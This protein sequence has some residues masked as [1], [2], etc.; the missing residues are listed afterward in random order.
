MLCL[1]FTVKRKERLD[2]DKL[3][4]GLALADIEHSG[5]ISPVPTSS[6]AI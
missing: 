3:D 4:V 1:V 2:R 5:A 6:V